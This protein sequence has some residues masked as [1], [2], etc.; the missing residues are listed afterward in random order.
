MNEV[1]TR[2]DTEMFEVT[3]DDQLESK[4]P[5][6]SHQP[7]LPVFVDVALKRAGNPRHSRLGL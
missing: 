2:D 3:E 4:S 7:V 1:R 5:P 6:I